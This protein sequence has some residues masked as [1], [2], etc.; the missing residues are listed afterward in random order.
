[1]DIKK[2]IVLANN[3]DKS[4]LS[5]EADFLDGII[6]KIAIKAP[7]GSASSVGPLITPVEDSSID[8]DDDIIIDLN[9]SGEESSGGDIEAPIAAP[10]EFALNDEDFSYLGSML[11]ISADKAGQW[12]GG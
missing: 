7:E 1:M 8:L 12:F 10:S 9:D 5:K 11:T 6:N 2:L 3:L 4:G